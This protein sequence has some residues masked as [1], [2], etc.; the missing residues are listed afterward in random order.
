MN[1]FQFRTDDDVKDRLSRAPIDSTPLN[2]EY[3]QF[4]QPPNGWEKKMSM[5][6]NGQKKIFS[7]EFKYKIK[8]DPREK[9]LF[10][11]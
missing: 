7:I 1:R 8:I 2:I 4:V 3:L 10:S 6:I 9:V 5:I 11:I